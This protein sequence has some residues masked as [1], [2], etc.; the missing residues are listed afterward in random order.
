[1]TRYRARDTADEFTISSGLLLGALS[2]AFGGAVSRDVVLLLASD[3]L[4]AMASFVAGLLV[5]IAIGKDLWVG[6]GAVAGGLLAAMGVLVPHNK[7]VLIGGFIL[8]AAVAL[9]YALWNLR[10]AT[11]RR[12]FAESTARALTATAVWIGGRSRAWRSQEFRADLIGYDGSRPCPSVWAQL[13]HS[14]GLVRAALV[15][16][17]GD[18]ARPFARLLDWALAKPRAEW[19]I[20]GLTLLSAIYFLRTGGFTGLMENL[21]N[22]GTVTLL[23]GPALWLRKSRDVQPARRRQKG[24]DNAENAMR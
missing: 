23:I 18:F 13:R 24:D 1:M 15:L 9:S 16:R 2:G 14:T 17:A 7:A 11:A 10:R 21:Q 8:Q 19:I 12:R 5:A 20:T 3:D 4:A 22:V 6:V